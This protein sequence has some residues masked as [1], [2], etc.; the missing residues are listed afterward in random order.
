LLFPDGMIKRLVTALLA[1]L[2]L[3][4]LPAAS[5]SAQTLDPAAADALATTLR[6]LADPAARGQILA[7]DP[8]AAAIDR[9]VQG[10]AG[11]SQLAQESAAWQPRS[12]G[13]ARARAATRGIERGAAARSARPPSRRCPAG[14]LD[15]LQARPPISDA[16]R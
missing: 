1:A 11:S 14:A 7:T 9:Q 16:Q 3:L 10:M 15:R 4:A 5:L 12:C 6:M 8:N 13:S 2:S